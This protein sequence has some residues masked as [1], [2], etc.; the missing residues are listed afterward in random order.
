MNKTELDNL[1]KHESTWE[2]FDAIERL[3]MAA[4]MTKEEAAREWRRCFLPAALL[5]EEEAKR[6]ANGEELLAVLRAAIQRHPCAGRTRRITVGSRL[7]RFEEERGRDAGVFHCEEVLAVDIA[8]D[9]VRTRNVGRFW[10]KDFAF[11]I[12]PDYAASIPA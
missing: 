11:V 9:T 8:R 2:E 1:T 10:A 3:Y 7:Y 6:P 12:D 5:R 4:N